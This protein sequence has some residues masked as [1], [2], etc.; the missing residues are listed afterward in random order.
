MSLDTVA[1]RLTANEEG[2]AV[3]GVHVV[4]ADGRRGEIN[5]HRYVLA[6]GGI[7]NARLLLDTAG[8]GAGLTVNRSVLGHYFMDHP[9]VR[10][11]LLQLNDSQRLESFGIYDKRTID[12][13]IVMGHVK[14]TAGLLEAHRLLSSA[15]L[16]FPRPREFRPAA[17]NVYQN[18]LP[19]RDWA[20]MLRATVA[21]R[22]APRPG[23]ITALWKL[24]KYGR[25]GL[26]HGGW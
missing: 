20:S 2:D 18:A 12:G 25:F 8:D 10:A 4:F 5:A 9:L 22:T 14:P 11:G 1:I 7:E 23:D 6:T 3:A 21:Q 16:M 24:R 15:F 26:A 19:D 17:M 13:S